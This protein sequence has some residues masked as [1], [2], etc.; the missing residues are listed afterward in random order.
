MTAKNDGRGCDSG[1]SQT[2]PKV[3]IELE[4][5]AEIAREDAYEFW[6]VLSN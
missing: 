5:L 6:W 3:P 2:S 1:L 4:V